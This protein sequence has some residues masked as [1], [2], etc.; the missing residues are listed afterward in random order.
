MLLDEQLGGLGTP[1]LEKM[2]RSEK[3]PLLMRGESFLVVRYALAV[4]IEAL[5][6]YGLSSCTVR[7]TLFVERKKVELLFS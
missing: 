5:P 4:A 2:G 3:I 7:A 1:L 6:A